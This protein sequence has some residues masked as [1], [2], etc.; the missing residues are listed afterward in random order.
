MPHRE[1]VLR[2]AMALPVEDRAY[3]VTI[4]ERTLVR[5]GSPSSRDTEAPSDG[6]SGAAFMAELERR[7]AAY[8][9][10]TAVVR[11]AAEVLAEMK[12]RQSSENP[13]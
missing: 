9:A 12:S 7:S 8:Q 13:P 5:G 2:Q 3:V 10:G 11:P 1:E 6:V 4:L